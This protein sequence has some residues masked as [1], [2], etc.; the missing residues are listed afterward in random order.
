MIKKFK[1]FILENDNLEK[2]INTFSKY[3]IGLSFDLIYQY[4]LKSDKYIIKHYN[5]RLPRF[6]IVYKT[7][8]YDIGRFSV[9]LNYKKEIQINDDCF[10]DSENF[11]INSIKDL[12]NYIE[13]NIKSRGSFDY[14]NGTGDAV[15]FK[16]KTYDT[17]HGSYY[18][19]F[20]KEWSD[21][22]WNLDGTNQYHNS[23]NKDIN[24]ISK[25]FNV[26]KIPSK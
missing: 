20:L 19:D 11:I 21:Y 25:Y 26:N 13:K 10:G 8:Y 7:D 2:S 18:D 15:K 1:D 9:I 24:T 5:E 16:Y 3:N 14:T 12:D 23:M 17:I 4:V 6:Y 22:S